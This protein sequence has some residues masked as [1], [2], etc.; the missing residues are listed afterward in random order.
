L[1]W[2]VAGRA[3]LKGDAYTLVCPNET[4][5]AG[6]LVRHLE[7]ANQVVAPELLGLANQSK[8]FQK[9]RNRGGSYH[10]ALCPCG[11]WWRAPTARTLCNVGWGSEPK[12][13]AHPRRTT[14][15]SSL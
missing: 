2:E 7:Q 11:L 10:T 8:G 3:G 12:S 5:F 9:A 14:S 4:N 6:E 15:V 13:T 1:E